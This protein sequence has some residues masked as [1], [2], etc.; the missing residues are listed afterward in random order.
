LIDLGDKGMS[1]L[2]Q[3]KNL[4]VEFKT[5]KGI[6]KAVKNISFTIP[7]GKTIG[8]VGESGS[9]K[10][11]SS[12][13]I[14]GLIPNPPGKVTSG[15]LI[16][17]GKDLLKCS[18]SEMRKLRG[19]K[20]SM[21]FQEPMTSLNPVFTVGDQIAESLILHKGMSKAEAL[22]K[23]VELMDQVGIPNPEQRVKAYPHEMSG[24][25]RQRVM[26]AMAI[27][28]EPDLL[29]ADEP[30]TALDV[31]IQK[32]ILELLEDLQ[33][34]YG[35][36]VLFI[37]HDLAV[38]ADI[39]DEVVVMY[40]GDIVEQG[41]TESLFTHAKHPYT[42]GLLACR[43]S[44]ESNPVR[45]PTVSDFMT[46]DGKE[47]DFDPKTLPVAEVTRGF[48][49]EKNP[50]ILEIK[51]L[52]KHF[53][54][55]KGF[56]GGVKRWLKAVDNVSLKVRKGR[57]LGLVGESGCG[58]TTL[59]RTILRLLE[60]TSGDIIYKGTN[61]TELNNKELRKLRRNMQIIFQ[62]PYSSLNPRMTVGN[63]I[64][65]PL[66]IHN[67]GSNKEERLEIAGDLIEKCGLPRDVLNRYP[68]EFSG[69]QR[70]RICI[71]RAL[72][73]KPE[74]IICDESV[75]ALDVSVQA[76]ILNL[77]L[78]LQEEFDLTYIFISH[79]LAVVKYI[80]DEVAVMN[81]GKVVEMADSFNIYE[82]PKDDYTVKL[83]SAI[84]KGIPKTLLNV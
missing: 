28:C 36:S 4:S 68:H 44:L 31:T 12:L 71:A 48:T 17:N 81:K 29:I 13:A 23:A 49:E 10:S 83:L 8:L 55:E 72:A 74:F 30:T 70:Q 41:Q 7:R 51:N 32:Q 6:V 59:G 64:M 33:K 22:A 2:L 78:D 56:F 60:P 19:N 73:V 80:S 3:I 47:K 20:I 15:E 58:K 1:D 45:L 67:I 69:G 57:T 43:P 5:E 14:M 77:L 53:P 35:M 42:K 46:K 75:S 66:V 27:A 38:I 39:A 25:Q 76:Q 34:K 18:D 82:N 37:T 65:E 84:P 62:D 52:E 24:G 50:V 16:Y 79:D 11:V 9:G 21:I 61:I 54:L 63:A 40:Q 26:I